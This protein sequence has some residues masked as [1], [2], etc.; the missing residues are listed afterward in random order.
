MSDCRRFLVE[1]KVQGV[2][3]RESTRQQAQRLQISGHAINLPDGRVEVIACGDAV[4]VSEL[5]DWLRQ[6]P[7]LARVTAVA[8]EP[9]EPLSSAGF[10][11]G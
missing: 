7:R 11:T 8:S 1:G 9:C 10:T 6:G 5:A 3:F 2:W 4:A